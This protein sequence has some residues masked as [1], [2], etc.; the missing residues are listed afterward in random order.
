MR[1]LYNLLQQ[2]LAQKHGAGCFAIGA[3]NG[4]NMRRL[5]F[6]KTCA[7]N[8]RSRRG[9]S[10]VTTGTP[11][12]IGSCVKIAAAPFSIACPTKERPSLHPGQSGE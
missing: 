6:K 11:A 12:T 9:L 3:G 8:A 2:K 7:I 10:L 1:P 4:G 5:H